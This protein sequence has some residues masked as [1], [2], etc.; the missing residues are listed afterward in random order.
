MRIDGWIFMGLAW[1]VLITLFVYCLARTL[2]HKSN[3]KD[4]E[5]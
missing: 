1:A 2:G 5:S 4:D 3:K